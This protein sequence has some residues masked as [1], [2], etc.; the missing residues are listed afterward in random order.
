MAQ[1]RMIG[2]RNKVLAIN[3]HIRNMVD[4][5]KYLGKIRNKSNDETEIKTRIA[6]AN[7]G[8]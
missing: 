4:N 5:F 1:S 3:E 6:V 8:C 2:T 7:R